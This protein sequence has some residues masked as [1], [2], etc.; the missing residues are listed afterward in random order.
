VE[1]F[2]GDVNQDESRRIKK[3]FGMISIVLLKV[4]CKLNA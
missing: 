2:D 3:R 4:E 1:R